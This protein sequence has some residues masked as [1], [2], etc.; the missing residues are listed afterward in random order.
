MSRK[1]PY[2]GDMPVDRARQVAQEFRRAL[3][4]VDPDACAKIEQAAIEVG[5]TWAADAWAVE[6]ETDAVTIPRAA[7]LVGR[8]TRWAYNLAQLHPELVCSRNPI[9]LRLRDVHEAAAAERRRRARTRR[10]PDPRQS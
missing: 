4:A 1:W 6:T 5:E 8:S 10:C 2:P 3:R 9:K 7:E